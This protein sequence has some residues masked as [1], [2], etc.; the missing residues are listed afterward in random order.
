MTFKVIFYII[1]TNLGS[2]FKMNYFQNHVIM[3]TV[4]KSLFYKSVFTNHVRLKSVIQKFVCTLTCNF[5]W[6]K[7]K[8]NLVKS[9]VP[10][11][12][13]ASMNSVKQYYN[14]SRFNKPTIFLDNWILLQC[15]LWCP[16][17]VCSMQCLHSVLQ[18]QNLRTSTEQ[19]WICLKSFCSENSRLHHVIK[20]L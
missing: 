13:D 4:I 19:I 20:S 8:K 9:N 18:N 1:Y 2:I 10:W 3:N 17:T 16:Q 14:Y 11:L 5:T 12:Y 15:L 6:K 7:K